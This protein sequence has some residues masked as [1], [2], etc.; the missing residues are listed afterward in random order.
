MNTD[1]SIQHYDVVV[2]GA[3]HAGCEAG[4]AAARAGCSTLVVTPNLDRIGFMPCNPSMGGPGKSQILAE[5]DALGGA[6][7]RVADMTTVQA[8]ELNTSKGPAV[9][10]IRVQCDK[11][12]YSLAMK[13][14]LERQENLDILQDEATGLRLDTLSASAPTVTGVELRASGPIACD[15][16]II[17]AGTFL[18]ARMISGES[19]SAGGRA[20]EHADTR[21]SGSLADLGLRLMRFKTGTPMRLDART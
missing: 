15:A 20:G 1:S 6:M 9:R 7:A 14:E 12:L 17:T 13:E 5:I 21:L 8:R 18:R 11:S 19:S 2:I 10:A 3:G 16:V 4:L